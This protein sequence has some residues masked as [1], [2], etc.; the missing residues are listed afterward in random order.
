LLLEPSR[1]SLITYSEAAASWS[2]ANV[3]FT[4]NTVVSPDG[5]QDAD[6]V[7]AD[8]TSNPH[9]FGFNAPSVTAGTAYTASIFVK[10]GTGQYF[11]LLFGSGGFNTTKYINYDLTAGTITY[12][13]TGSSGTITSYGNGW[14]RLTITATCDTST[15]ETFY[16]A[17]ITTPT[18]ARV[19]SNTSTAYYYAWGAQLEAGAYATSY[20]P[21]L[22]TSVT[23]VADAASKT[24]ISSLI[25]QT[26]GTLFMEFNSFAASYPLSVLCSVTNGDASKRAYAEI[27]GTTLT[28]G[29][30][31]SAVSS[32]TSP[33]ASGTNKVA[34]A[35]KNGD[36]AFYHNG[37]LK[38]TGTA[39][40]D[41]AGGVDI[42][43]T[44]GL[45]FGNPIYAYNEKEELKQALLFKTRLTNAQLAELTTL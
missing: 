15:T 29:F 36:I 12:T 42:F 9:Y 2:A 11:Q 38:G 37:V 31:G 21:T 26:E 7:T 17:I 18:A 5:Y 16:G 40:V 28:M 20:I 23:R 3:T 22:G 13:G 1:T 35:Y 30:I 6:T 44:Y 14:Y 39:N 34:I 8:G 43:N 25:G 27:L 41:W 4:S 10:N 33:I 24:G 32:A 19:Q 45:Y